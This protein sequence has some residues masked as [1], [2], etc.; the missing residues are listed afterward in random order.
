[1]D[2][3]P[4][5]ACRTPY[6]LLGHSA[7]E[8]RRRAGE[9]SENLPFIFIYIYIKTYLHPGDISKSLFLM[10]V[11]SLS[12]SIQFQIHTQQKSVSVMMVISMQHLSFLFHIVCF[13]TPQTICMLH[14]VINNANAS[15]YGRFRSIKSIGFFSF[16]TLYFSHWA[17]ANIICISWEKKNHFSLLFNFQL[18]AFSA[19]ERKRSKL[20]GLLGGEIVPLGL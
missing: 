10:V 11:S 9:R 18:C 1:M 15:P 4:N 7:S 13:F 17:V 2:S 20:K 3:C 19:V 14:T 5:G 12:Y 16:H 6:Y 8:R